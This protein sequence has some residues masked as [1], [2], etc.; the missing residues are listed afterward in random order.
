M[1]S[2]KLDVIDNYSSAASNTFSASS[3]ETIAY[4]DSTPAKAKALFAS[5]YF[6]SASST[7]GKYASTSAF[8]NYVPSFIQ[9]GTSSGSA[10]SSDSDD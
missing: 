2:Y 9:S 6:V 1:L 7:F 10:Y 8:A 3:F 5:S 4:E